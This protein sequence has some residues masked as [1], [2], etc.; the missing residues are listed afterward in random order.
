M[1][2][3][4]QAEKLRAIALVLMLLIP[5][6]IY[7]AANRWGVEWVLISLGLMAV[8]MVVVIKTG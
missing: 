8:N 2:S 3:S 1:A 6:F 7:I 4:K 5:F